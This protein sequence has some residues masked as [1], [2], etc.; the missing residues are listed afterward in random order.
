MGAIIATV[1]NVK[2]YINQKEILATSFISHKKDHNKLFK[3]VERH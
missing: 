3:D 1:I 2:Y